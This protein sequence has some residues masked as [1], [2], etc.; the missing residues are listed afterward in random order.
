MIFLPFLLNLF[1][2]K[3][4]LSSNRSWKLACSK[5]QKF[6]KVGLFFL[7][8]E[9]CH[10]TK[11]TR[12]KKEA[13][14]SASVRVLNSHRNNGYFPWK[15]IKNIYKTPLIKQHS[16]V[17]NTVVDLVQLHSLLA[18][19]QLPVLNIIQIVKCLLYCT[20][21]IVLDFVQNLQDTIYPKP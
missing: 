16:T 12:V 19:S 9:R 2:N 8:F 4:C 3:F 15:H 11:Y 21:S 1:L 10:G 14:V 5:F 18:T 7:Y 6:L 20:V 17:W 13:R